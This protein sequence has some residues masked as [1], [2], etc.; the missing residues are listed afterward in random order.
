METSPANPFFSFARI[1]EP[2]FGFFHGFPVC[3]AHASGSSITL[4]EPY[5]CAV[6]ASTY[7]LVKTARV[8][9]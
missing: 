3:F 9:L 8:V 6:G 4:N 1:L 2:I 7:L 5:H